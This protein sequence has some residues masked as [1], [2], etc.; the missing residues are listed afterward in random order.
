[1]KILLLMIFTIS[2]LVTHLRNQSCQEQRRCIID[3]QKTFTTFANRDKMRNMAYC[4]GVHITAVRAP[5]EIRE[6]IFAPYLYDNLGSLSV[7]QPWIYNGSLPQAYG[8][9]YRWVVRL[10]NRESVPYYNLRISIIY[11]NT[12]SESHNPLSS[13]QVT[14]GHHR[15]PR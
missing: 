14:H 1:M 9:V 11:T 3:L 10:V 7:R 15:T 4:G 2:C 5:I 13:R 6:M 12:N 8:G